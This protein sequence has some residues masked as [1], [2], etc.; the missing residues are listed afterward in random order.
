[1]DVNLQEWIE[2]HVAPVRKRTRRGAELTQRVLQRSYERL[3]ISEA[4]LRTPL[5]GVWHPQRPKPQTN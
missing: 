4:L 3:E 5:P 1:M 2:Q